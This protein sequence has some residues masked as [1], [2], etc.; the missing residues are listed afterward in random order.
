MRILVL[1]RY[2]F[3]VLF[4]KYCV[5]IAG[6][7]INKSLRS[8]P[9]RVSFKRLLLHDLSKFSRAEFLPYAEKFYGAGNNHEQF[10]QAWVHH[11]E[12]NDHHSEH[13]IENYS[14]WIKQSTWPDDLIVHPMPDEAI[15]EMVADNLA[16][17]R[18]YEGQWPQSFKRHGWPW[19]NDNFHKFRLHPKTKIKFQLLLSVIGFRFVMPEPFDWLILESLEIS[20]EEKENISQLKRLIKQNEKIKD[21]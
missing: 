2:F 20:D 16:A 21:Q 6:L 7:Q 5:L 10:Q 19:M 13:F 17:S 1:L 15:V 9:F 12:N 14:F 4:H 8:T 3:S 18:S 11:V